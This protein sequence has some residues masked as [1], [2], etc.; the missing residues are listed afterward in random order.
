MH[1]S[2]VKLNRSIAGRLTEAF[3]DLIHIGPLRTEPSRFYYFSG[4]SAA[5]VGRHG[6]ST[7]KLLAALHYQGRISE[8]QTAVNRWLRR[9]GYELDVRVIG[10]SP[11]VQIGV[12]EGAESGRGLSLNLVDVGFGISQVLPLLVQCYGGETGRTILLEQPELHLHPRAQA[13]LGDLLQEVAGKHRLLIETHS[14]H[15]LLR[16]RRRMAEHGGGANSKGLGVDQIAVYF[17]ERS[18]GQ[19]Q[20]SRINFDELGQLREAPRGFRE[21]FSDDYEETVKIQETLS[22]RLTAEQRRR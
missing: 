7:Y 17:V 22:R 4:E 11:L 12:R 5:S 3:R 1:P 13:D 20:V 2:L 21:F 8:L 16:L 19:S 15:L 18:E 9:L 6:E 14:E 10:K